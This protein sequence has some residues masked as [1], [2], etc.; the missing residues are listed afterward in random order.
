MK[1]MIIW[2]AVGGLIGTVLAGYLGHNFADGDK[3]IAILIGVGCGMLG[4]L[5]GAIGALWRELD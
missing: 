4:T 5:V 3:L 1:R 2:M